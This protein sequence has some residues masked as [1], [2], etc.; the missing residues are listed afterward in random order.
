MLKSSGFISISV[1]DSRVQPLDNAQYAVV[2]GALVRVRI[3]KQQ[4]R[5][6]HTQPATT[7]PKCKASHI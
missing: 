6:A 2:F 1:I 3:T 4:G 5:A 7:S